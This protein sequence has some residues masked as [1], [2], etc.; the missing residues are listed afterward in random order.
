[1]TKAEK[2]LDDYNH[3]GAIKNYNKTLKCVVSKYNTTH[4]HTDINP[5]ELSQED[6][7]SFFTAALKLALIHAS[8]SY[9]KNS[10]KNSQVYINI[11]SKSTLPKIHCQLGKIYLSTDF[12][13]A[14]TE[15][16]K[17]HLS[18]AANLGHNEAKQILNLMENEKRD[19][20]HQIEPDKTSEQN[21][22]FDSGSITSQETSSLQ[23]TSNRTSLMDTNTNE[24]EWMGQDRDSI[25]AAAEHDDKD[26]QFTL[27]Y[28]YENGIGFKKSLPAAEIWY[29]RAAERDHWDAHCNL[30]FLYEK[31]KKY[32]KAFK[33]YKPAAKRGSLQ[34]QYNLGCLYAQGLGTSADKEKSLHWFKQAADNGHHEAQANVGY[35]YLKKSNYNDANIYYREAAKGGV[36]RAQFAI[37]WILENTT[38]DPKVNP[39]V[40]PKDI[41]NIVKGIY[42]KCSKQGYPPGMNNLGCF[43]EKQGDIGKALEYY[44]MAEK[45]GCD[46]A[47]DNFKRLNKENQSP[48]DNQDSRPLLGNFGNKRNPP[49]SH[50]K[51]EPL[52][53]NNENNKTN[54]INSTY[55]I[56]QNVIHGFKYSYRSFKELQGCRSKAGWYELDST[57]QYAKLGLPDNNYR[58]QPYS[59]AENNPAALYKL[60]SMYLLADGV[61]YDLDKAIKCLEKAMT[62]PM[63]QDSRFI[64]PL[65]EDPELCIKT[66]SQL[67][68]EMYCALGYLY[69]HKGDHLNKIKHF[70]TASNKGCTEAKEEV[71]EIINQQNL[72]SINK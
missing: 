44:K 35:C 41:P 49:N 16:A 69:E 38:G 8:R 47:K 2:H 37:G 9:K 55:F 53:K 13:L 20:I 22:G 6:Q 48:K 36:I 24:T 26:S 62:I 58:L 42:M 65:E 52:G 7:D 34:A 54:K 25:K 71:K 12:M 15:K 5:N 3:D 23:S 43:Y 72:V 17:H 28:M 45:E 30:G 67:L 56:K 68:A 32:N 29:K 19:S 57:E 66:S 21:S 40:D 18:Y 63:N 39:K 27:G 4:T 64:C 50:D 14:N 33:M 61:N 11:C 10:K 1:M 60:S 51:P 31:Q 59:N 70:V 46:P